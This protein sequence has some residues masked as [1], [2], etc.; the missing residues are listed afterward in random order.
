MLQSGKKGVK[1]EII[2]DNSQWKEETEQEKGQSNEGNGLELQPLSEEVS[3]RLKAFW[4]ES[5]R[6][7]ANYNPKHDV[8]ILEILELMPDVPEYWSAGLNEE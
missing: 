4:E 2:Y 8:K 7:K 3:N 1:L 6:Q 5:M